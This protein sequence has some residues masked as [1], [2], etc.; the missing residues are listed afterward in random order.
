[1]SDFKPASFFLTQVSGPVGFGIGIGQALCGEPSRY[2]H[3]GIVEDTDGKTIE[4]QPGGAIEGH[5]SHYFG[6]PLLIC[7]GPIL[8]TLEKA[9]PFMNADT[10]AAYEQRLRNGV[11]T[12]A[13]KLIGVPYSAL[14]YFALA[15]LHLGLP[16]TWIRNRVEKSGHLICSEL[17]DLSYKRAGIQL[18]QDD[19]M[20]GDVLPSDLASW[21]EDWAMH[22]QSLATPE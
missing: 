22:A 17:V 2:G 19:R 20:P 6:R 13:R 4:A 3:A 9:D 1:M 7:D 11:V 5:I 21:A 16:N 12:E 10:L 18:F 8:S 15:A 14:D